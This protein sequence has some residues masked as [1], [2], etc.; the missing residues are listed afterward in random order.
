MAKYTID[1]N[2]WYR[3]KSHEGSSLL[4]SDGLMCCLGQMAK[5]MGYS[6]EELEYRV[7]PRSLLRAGIDNK[8]PSYL[9]NEYQRQTDTCCRMMDINDCPLTSDEQREQRLIEIAAANGDEL[10][11][12]G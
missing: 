7:E 4:R 9:I 8:F 3:G 10:E 6:K 11:F 1:R 2:T 5:Q 12:I